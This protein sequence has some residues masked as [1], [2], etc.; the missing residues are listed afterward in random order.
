MSL[1]Q[2]GKYKWNVLDD[3][4]IQCIVCKKEFIKDTKPNGLATHRHYCLKN[5]A[6]KGKKAKCAP[7]KNGNG[8]KADMSNYCG[9]ENLDPQTQMRRKGALMGQCK[10]CHNAV[11]RRCNDNTKKNKSRKS[12]Q[13]IH[14]AKDKVTRTKKERDI[15]YGTNSHDGYRLLKEDE[16]K[17]QCLDIP[18]NQLFWSVYPWAKARFNKN[19]FDFDDEGFQVTW[20]G[21]YGIKQKMLVDAIAYWVLSPKLCRMKATDFDV[22]KDFSLQQKLNMQKSMQFIFIQGFIREA[23]NFEA[24]GN[25][26]RVH[27]KKLKTDIWPSLFFEEIWYAIAF[28]WQNAVKHDETDEGNGH[29][30]TKCIHNLRVINYSKGKKPKHYEVEFEVDR[31][32][33]GAKYIIKHTGGF[34]IW[35]IRTAVDREYLWQDIENYNNHLCKT[36]KFFKRSSTKVQQLMKQ[37]FN[38]KEWKFLLQ[39]YDRAMRMCFS[40]NMLNTD[41]ILFGTIYL[42]YPISAIKEILKYFKEM[43]KQNGH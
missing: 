6:S 16:F 8:R 24:D 27:T 43:S 21:A 3:G 7:G 14:Q 12:F 23:F 10:K 31:Q 33:L 13:E 22:A 28:A 18:A 20:E 39:D 41:N 42:H 35:Q 11:Q 29:T 4:T 34:N 38:S 26:D 30:Y 19:E 36:N 40:M 15:I 9:A 2:K 32:M 17:S 37:L 25:S 1:V 5:Q